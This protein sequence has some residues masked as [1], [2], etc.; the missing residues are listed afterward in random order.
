[1]IEADVSSLVLEDT[2]R[3][4]L[5]RWRA[6]N[7]HRDR[8]AGIYLS[9]HVRLAG[10]LAVLFDVHDRGVVHRAAALLGVAVPANIHGRALLVLR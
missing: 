9:Q 1:V 3:V 7:G 6:G 2:T 10:D 5:K 4:V 8:T